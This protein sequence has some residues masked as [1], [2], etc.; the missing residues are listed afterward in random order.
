[1]DKYERDL[2]ISPVVPLARFSLCPGFLILLHLI[3]V[4]QAKTSY[5]INSKKVQYLSSDRSMLGSR[6]HKSQRPRSVPSCRSRAALLMSENSNTDASLIRTVCGYLPLKE[7]I[8]NKRLSQEPDAGK[9]PCHRD[10]SRSTC[11]T[12]ASH[13]FYEARAFGILLGFGGS[14]SYAFYIK[15]RKFSFMI[16]NA[17]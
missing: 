3:R 15:N 5:D 12:L 16:R 2:R 10:L 11:R 7:G 8:S 1:M 6:I 9:D 14:Y 4:L 13:L 17:R